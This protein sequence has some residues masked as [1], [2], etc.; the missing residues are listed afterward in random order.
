MSWTTISNATATAGQ[1]ATQELFRALRDN[2]GAIAES[3]TGA[4]V[5]QS[6]WH[7]YN[8]ADVGGGNT[9]AFWSFANQGALANVTTPTFSDGYEYMIFGSGLS[10]S[11]GGGGQGLV[12]DYNINGV[13]FIELTRRTAWGIGLNDVFDFRLYCPD[14]RRSSKV[15]GGQFLAGFDATSWGTGGTWEHLTLALNG[16]TNSVVNSV[17]FSFATGPANFDAGVMYLF[18]RQQL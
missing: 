2:P 10:P 8:L 17:N 13:G 1:P 18:R 6:L 5:N 16:N 4:P 7:P 14:V 3:A 12:I 15:H 9:G 11:F